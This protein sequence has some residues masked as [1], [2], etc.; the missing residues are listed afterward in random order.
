[1]KNLIKKALIII[2]FFGLL[3]FILVF[4]NCNTGNKKIEIKGIWQGALEYPGGIKLQVIFNISKLPNGELKAVVL[5]PDLDDDEIPVKKISFKKNHLHMILNSVPIYFEGNLYPDKNSIDGRWIQGKQTFPLVLHKINKIT[6]PQRP[7]EPKR[8]FPYREK[9]VVFENLEAPARLSG[10][11][12]LPQ[13]RGG[14]K[15]V[16]V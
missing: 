8:P 5:R 1:M 7:Q 6:K 4:L 14:V 10:T 3:L 11:L 16:T 15:T 9:D 13:K 2:R 12:T